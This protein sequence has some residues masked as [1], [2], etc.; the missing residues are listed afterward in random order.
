MNAKEKYVTLSLRKYLSE[1]RK[2]ITLVYY[3][4]FILLSAIDLREKD[5]LGFLIYDKRLFRICEYY[6]TKL[7]KARISFLFVPNC[8]F[9]R[10]NKF[11]DLLNQSIEPFF[12]L[13]PV[14]TNQQ[15]AHF[16]FEKI[17][18]M[19]TQNGAEDFVTYEYK[20]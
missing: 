3:P 11:L 2:E 18:Q 16:R 20:G 9:L 19:F 6:K 10:N 4:G 1:S 15:I 5:L 12:L 17:K 13:N 14:D 8:E 7:N